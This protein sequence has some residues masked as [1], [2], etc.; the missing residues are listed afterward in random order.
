MLTFVKPRNTLFLLALLSLLLAVFPYPARGFRLFPWRPPARAKPDPPPDT[1]TVDSGYKADSQ[2]VDDDD[3]D[4]DTL[5]LPSQTLVQGLANFRPLQRGPDS[6]EPPR[7]AEGNYPISLKLPSGTNSQPAKTGETGSE[8]KIQSL[9]DSGDSGA[10]GGSGNGDTSDDDVEVFEV[11][12]PIARPRGVKP[13][14]VTLLRNQSFDDT[15]GDPPVAK[16]YSIPASC[17]SAWSLVLLSVRVKVSGVQF[18]RVLSVFIGNFEVSRSITVE[19]LGVSASYSFEE[20]I[21]KFASALAKEKQAFVSL[22]NVINDTLTGV[23]YV[24]IDLLYFKT[25]RFNRAIV[26]DVVLPFSSQ[27]LGKPYPVP[28]T[29]TGEDSA[30]TSSSSSSSSPS[31]PSLEA[32]VTFPLLPLDIVTAKFELMVTRH[33]SDEFFFMLSPNSTST[34]STASSSSSS[35]SSSYSP[36]SSSSP[37]PFRE[38]LLFIDNQFAGAVFPFPTLYPSAFAPLLWAPL[39]GIGCFSNPTYSLDITPFVGLLVDG[40]PH[41]IS[42]SMPAV[43]RAA[44]WMVSGVLQLWVDP[45]R[46]ATSGTQPFINAPVPSIINTFITPPASDLSNALANNSFGSSSNNNGNSSSSTGTAAE[47]APLD[48]ASTSIGFTTSTLRSYTITGTVYSSAGAVTTEVTGS[49]GAEASVYFRREGLVAWSHVTRTSVEVT[50][51]DAKG[52]ELSSVTEQFLFPVN[53]KM[54]SLDANGSFK[55]D[56]DYA[57]NLQRDKSGR[58]L[59]RD[60]QKADALKPESFGSQ[61]GRDGS[62]RDDDT[63]KPTPTTGLDY[64]GA[65]P[66][67]KASTTEGEATRNAERVASAAVQGG[68]AADG[69]KPHVAWLRLVEQAMEGGELDNEKFLEKM[70]RRLD[71]AAAQREVPANLPLPHSSDPPHSPSYLT[72]WASRCAEWRVGVSFVPLPGVEARFEEVSASRPPRCKWGMTLLLG[73]PGSGKSTLLKIHFVLANPDQHLISSLFLLHTT[74][75]MLFPTR[76]MTLLLGPPGSGKSTLLKILAGKAERELRV[77]GEVTYNGRPGSHFVLPRTVAFV[78]QTDSHIGEMTVRE[79]L[80]FSARLQGPGYKAGAF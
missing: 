61:G 4:D 2:D 5:L 70:R 53:L 31:S 22:P 38:L 40:Q 55:L 14:V 45:V 60:A 11:A 65:A 15:V 78:P 72:A 48:P 63:E 3:D 68:E 59:R 75:H 77:Q 32:S 51:K 58:K 49:L 34:S 39:V 71:R 10:S 44:R 37:S 62:V 46:E 33:G 21:T 9:S 43:G 24:S 6:L 27:A 47:P 16:N 26:P 79:T 20:D 1:P 42:V 17:G 19:P 7:P 28:F 36:S 57:F 35:S 23:F 18:D 56:T 13:C 30:S 80:E 74:R 67:G 41:E 66:E 76:R 73:P 50:S 64:H 52:N 54:T 8:G 29:I 25:S 69:E 12:R